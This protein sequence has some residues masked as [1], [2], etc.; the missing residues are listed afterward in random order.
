M[1]ETFASVAIIGVVGSGKAKKA[2]SALP[3]ASD[4]GDAAVNLEA[5]EN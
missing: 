3:V 1:V 5:W 2:K 4:E